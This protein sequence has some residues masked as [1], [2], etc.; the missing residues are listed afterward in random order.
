MSGLRL[1]LLRLVTAALICAGAAALCPK[2]RQ[3]ILR[4]CCAC[5][6]AVVALAPLLRAPLTVPELHFEAAPQAAASQ[7]EA[8][9]AE[10]LQAQT[11]AALAA[12]IEHLAAQQGLR[13]TAEVT[14]DTA[15]GVFRVTAVTLKGEKSDGFT[16]QIAQRYG[17][18]NDGIVWRD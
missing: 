4:F 12:D 7:A 6:L 17:V 15:D 5:I 3:E 2:G 13:L 16:A 14:A 11:A 8:R 10:A 1:Y 9:A 18:E